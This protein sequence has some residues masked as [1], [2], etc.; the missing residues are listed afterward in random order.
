[1]EEEEEN[2]L[3]EVEQVE[4]ESGDQFKTEEPKME[5]KKDSV[6][7]DPDATPLDI[8]RRYHVVKRQNDEHIRRLLVAQG[9]IS[10]VSLQKSRTVWPEIKKF[11]EKQ[12]KSED[13]LKDWEIVPSQITIQ[14]PYTLLETVK[15]EANFEEVRQFSVQEIEKTPDWKFSVIPDYGDISSNKPVILLIKC[16][17]HLPA[18]PKERSQQNCKITVSVNGEIKELWIYIN[19]IPNYLRKVSKNNQAKHANSKIF[20]R[21]LLQSSIGE[22]KFK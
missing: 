2:T 18:F 3:D 1:M 17:P 10:E 16:E 6:L 21:K 14:P 20:Q 11:K 19:Y 12:Y 7:S 8:L 5:H 15:L 13:T 9:R 4:I 22:N